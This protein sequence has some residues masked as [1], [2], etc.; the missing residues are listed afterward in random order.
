M[1][2]S[3]FIL[4]NEAEKKR[5]IMKQAVALAQRTYRDR[6]IFLFQLEN[7]YVEVYCNTPDKSIEKYCI[8]PDTNAIYHYLEAISIDEI[9]N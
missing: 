7:Y 3:E 8:L 5:A 6:V 9:V 4:L 2:L 1:K